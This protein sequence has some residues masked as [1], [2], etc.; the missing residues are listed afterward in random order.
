MSLEHLVENSCATNWIRCIFN[1]LTIDS[2]SLMVTT[3]LFFY[4]SQM[5][6]ISRR[7]LTSP[8]FSCFIFLAKIFGLMQNG[9]YKL[10]LF[11]TNYA[12]NY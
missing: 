7:L 1:R 6:Y 2:I 9:K 5:L 8:T 12:T 4:S 10:F 11:I 3:L